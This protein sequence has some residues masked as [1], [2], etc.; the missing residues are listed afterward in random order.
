[1]LPPA[2]SA[3]RALCRTVPDQGTSMCTDKGPG[4]EID[5][6]FLA[7]GGQYMSVRRVLDM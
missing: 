2:H 3:G 4:P 1:M 5:T 7:W 6:G